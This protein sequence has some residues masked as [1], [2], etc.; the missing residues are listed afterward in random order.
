M[1]RLKELPDHERPCE[2][3]AACGVSV[4]TD[5]ELLAVVLRTGTR[6][7]DVLTLSS[8]ILELG[9]PARGL[10]GLMHLTKEEFASCEGI[11]SVKA[12]QLSALG[13]IAKRIWRRE[14]AEK[15]LCFSVPAD[16]AEYY[17]EELRH[18]EQEELHAVF[19]D[20]RMRRIGDR[21]ISRGTVDSSVFSVR[22]VLI[23]ALRAGAVQMILI[24]NHP[25]GDPSPSAQDSAVTEQVRQAGELT[26]I[27]LADHIII[28]DTTYYSFKEWGIL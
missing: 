18:L 8:R 12:I 6:N 23:A 9:D 22:D 5:A 26:G 4:L 27:R 16:C 7:C 15:A 2:K 14:R 10:C 28:G 21:V 17:M 1:N 3:A 11:G 20:S 24:H 13:E 25:S 19:L